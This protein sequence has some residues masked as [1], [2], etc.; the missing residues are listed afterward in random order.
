MICSCNTFY[1]SFCSPWLCIYNIIHIKVSKVGNSVVLHFWCFFSQTWFKT[2][3]K[4]KQ[5]STPFHFVFLKTQSQTI[6]SGEA[7]VASFLA[8]TSHRESGR[9]D[10][11]GLR[12]WIPGAWGWHGESK[13]WKHSGRSIRVMNIFQSKHISIVGVYFRFNHSI[14]TYFIRIGSNRK[15]KSDKSDEHVA[16]V[17]QRDAKKRVSKANISHNWTVCTCLAVP[18]YISLRS[19]T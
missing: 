7:E 13:T 10:L 19:Q 14:Q 18:P 17:M 8:R 15:K 5:H 12:L 9:R 4:K 1:S 3:E 6:I 16:C 2:T 11:S